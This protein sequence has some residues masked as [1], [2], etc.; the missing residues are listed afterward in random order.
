MFYR[1]GNFRNYYLRRKHFLIIIKVCLYAKDSFK[2]TSIFPV[3]HVEKKKKKQNISNTKLF[4]SP[5]FDVMS[6]LFK[7]HGK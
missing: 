2:K 4:E 3:S 6:K 7:Y 5:E 1:L